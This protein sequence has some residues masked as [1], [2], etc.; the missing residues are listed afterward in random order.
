MAPKYHPTPLSGGDRK[1]LAKELG[2]A[3]AMT[4]VFAPQSE[5]LRTQGD[6]N[7]MAAERERSIGALSL[8]DAENPVRSRVVDCDRTLVVDYQ[9]TGLGKN[10]VSEI[11]LR[12]D[13]A[14]RAQAGGPPVCR[15]FR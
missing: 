14:R 10:G 3:R 6:P 13:S 7:G 1:A 9:P 2:K 5:E 8:R 4:T 15:A 11:I 12:T